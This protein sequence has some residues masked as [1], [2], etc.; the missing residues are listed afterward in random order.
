MSTFESMLRA[1]R[2]SAESRTPLELAYVAIRAGRKSGARGSRKR[3]SDMLTQE[4]LERRQPLAVDSFHQVTNHNVSP[5]TPGWMVITATE[6]VY[7]QQVA[8]SP[9][10]L[11][12]ADNSSFADAKS[13]KLTPQ[14]VATAFNE[15][16]ISARTGASLETIGIDNAIGTIYVTNGERRSDS[17][18]K[19]LSE[20]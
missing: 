3:R 6:D 13:L 11:I 2:S 12:F 14:E 8:T 1:I 4:G 5:D 10:S 16:P 18:W 9:Q 7:I 17:P 15:L 20:R 19:Q